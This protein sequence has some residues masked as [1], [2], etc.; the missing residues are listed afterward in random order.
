MG[1]Y[2]D[3]KSI[4]E[5]D[6]AARNVLEVILLYP[7]FKALRDHRIA[8]F[9]LRHKMPLIARYV[10]QRSSRKTGIEIHPGATIGEGLFIDHGH[11]VVIGETAVVGDNCTL[12]HQVTLG[13]NGR[14][15]HSKRHPTV[16]NNVLI[17]AGAKI[18]GPVTIGNNSMIGSGSVVLGDVPPNSTVTGIKARVIKTDGERVES[19]SLL[20]E[21]QKIIDPVAQEIAQ[22]RGE[23]E[24]TNKRLAELENKK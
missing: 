24:A 8:S 10:S 22:L 7:G 9:F 16:G 23:L 5:R 21:H 6:P 14:E 11:G 3:A 12:Y 1:L 17:G 18:L 20:L 2:K 13:G 19:P 4:A 15:R